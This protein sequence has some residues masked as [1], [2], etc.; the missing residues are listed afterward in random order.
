M[1]K[2]ASIISSFLLIYFITL[3]SGCKKHDNTPLQ[4]SVPSGVYIVGEANTGSG[5]LWNSGKMNYLTDS[6]TGSGAYSLFVNGQDVYVGG[7]VSSSIYPNIPAYWKNGVITQLNSSVGGN[8]GWVNAIFVTGADVY[9]AG[10][11]GD[12]NHTY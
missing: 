7:E 2:S 11:T 6:T 10:T 3:L 1:K 8:N 12:W 4:V 5:V 9:A